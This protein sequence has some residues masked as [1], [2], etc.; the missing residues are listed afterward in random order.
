[1]MKCPLDFVSP[2]SFTLACLVMHNLLKMQLH[3]LQE[4]LFIQ[5]GGVFLQQ[6]MATHLLINVPL[7]SLCRQSSCSALQ[8]Q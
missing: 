2:P 1:M 5:S 8:Q 7:Y 4:S 3:R 6:L